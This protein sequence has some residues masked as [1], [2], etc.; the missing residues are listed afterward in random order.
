MCDAGGPPLIKWGVGNG[1]DSRAE[2]VGALGQRFPNP[3]PNAFRKRVALVGRRFGFT[4]ASLRLLRPRQLAP[5]LIVKTHRSRKAFVSDIGDIME[6]LDPV[7][8]FPDGT[9]G[10]FEGFFFAAEDARGPFIFS[11]RVMRHDAGGDGW[12]ANPCLYAWGDGTT[13]AGG[14]CS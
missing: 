1:V 7:T 3:S 13:G 12:V 10:T 2:S 11:E 4:V 6:L 8:D 14:P 5:L 9:A